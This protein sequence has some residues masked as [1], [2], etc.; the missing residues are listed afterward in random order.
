MARSN[1]GRNT[2][3]TIAVIP[4]VAAAVV[5][6]RVSDPEF[7]RADVGIAGDHTL[8]AMETF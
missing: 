7:P 3:R 5:N 6:V 8:F 4:A 2:K 1:S